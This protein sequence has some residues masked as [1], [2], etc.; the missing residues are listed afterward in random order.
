MEERL[1]S[2]SP[3]PKKGKL[4]RFLV[5]TKP[6]VVSSEEVGGCPPSEANGWPSLPR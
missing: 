6:E 4:P 3:D 5:K 1:H 2:K